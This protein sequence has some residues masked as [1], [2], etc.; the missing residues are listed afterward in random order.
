MIVF[1]GYILIENKNVA[2]TTTF[3]CMLWYLNNRIKK[4]NL[5]KGVVVMSNNQITLYDLLRKINSDSKDLND[6]LDDMFKVLIKKN[7]DENEYYKKMLELRKKYPV[8]T[9]F[10]NISNTISRNTGNIV[11][12]KSYKD[13]LI[14]FLLKIAFIKVCNEYSIKYN[15][16]KINNYNYIFNI[17]DFINKNSVY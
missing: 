17:L 16:N 8:E 13:Y 5:K 6:I 4:C 3:F 1:I 9:D 7:F 15:H 2:F 12:A 14:D 11:T 10:I